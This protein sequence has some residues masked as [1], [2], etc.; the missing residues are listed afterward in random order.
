VG[1]GAYSGWAERPQPGRGGDVSAY[2][3]PVVALS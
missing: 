1:E 2:F 3:A